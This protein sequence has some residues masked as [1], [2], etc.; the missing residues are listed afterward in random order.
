MNGRANT[1]KLLIVNADDFGFTRDV[2]EG[3]VHAHTH[4]ILTAATLMANGGAFDHA[5]ELAKRHPSLDIGCHLVLVGGRSPLPPHKP[6]PKDLKALLAAIV[7]RQLAVER[8]LAAQIEKILAAGVK[9]T[10]LDTHKHTHLLPPVLET[11]ARLSHRY[12]IPWVRRPFDY[13]MS[14][15]GVPLARRLLSRSLE[16][17]RRRFH[18]AL[19]SRGCRTTDHF[20]GFQLTGHF[21][22]RELVALLEQL[23]PGSTEFMTHPGFCTGELL[24]SRTRLKESR[25]RELDALT[26]EETREAVK[27]LGIRL[28]CYRDL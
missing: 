8:E 23:P 26:A 20:A 16:V 1:E 5:V 10:H 3:I 2:N 21:D 4:G 17:L 22:A 15:A 28:V 14:A 9:P 18:R 7:K 27:R 13:P 11:V 24:S 12:G 6:Y 25:R 19:S